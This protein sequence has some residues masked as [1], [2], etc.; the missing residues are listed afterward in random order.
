MDTL[1]KAFASFEVRNRD[2]QI[3]TFLRGVLDLRPFRTLL[4]VLHRFGIVVPVEILVKIRSHCSSGGLDDDISR[5]ALVLIGRR[6]SVGERENI[7]SFTI[8]TFVFDESGGAIRLSSIWLKPRR[9][10]SPWGASL[11]EDEDAG[12]LRPPDLAFNVSVVPLAAMGSPY[13]YP[14]IMLFEYD[15]AS[16][17]EPTVLKDGHFIP[18][19]S[20]LLFRSGHFEIR[21]EAAF[22]LLCILAFAGYDIPKADLQW[23]VQLFHEARQEGDHK[24]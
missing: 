22:E 7:A 24:V 20:R 14:H 6:F 1:P 17:I 5:R 15:V 16:R 23:P 2:H 19:L 13:C 12:P 10:V 9:P 21:P 4:L 11:S 3:E 8:P 18:L